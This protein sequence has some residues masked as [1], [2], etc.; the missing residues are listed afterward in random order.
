MQRVL[1]VVPI[2]EHQQYCL[3]TRT[4][5]TERHLFSALWALKMKWRTSPCKAEHDAMTQALEQ[6]HK[7]KKKAS[8]LPL[9]VWPV[10]TSAF[11]R[12]MFYY[13]QGW[14]HVST[15]LTNHRRP[16]VSPFPSP[17]HGGFFHQSQELTS[18]SQF[19]ILCYRYYTLQ[20][21][22][23]K[24]LWDTAQFLFSSCSKSTVVHCFITSFDKTTA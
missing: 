20:S 16:R 23:R 8:H 19:L 5:F 14:S 12:R 4:G 24:K 18:N 3:P 13:S 17:E 22:T 7:M 15:L 11:Q 10:K 9:H 1:V 21:F 2:A 6:Q